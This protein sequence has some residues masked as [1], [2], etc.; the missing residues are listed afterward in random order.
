MLA[1]ATV[2][3]K[4]NRE[5]EATSG[6]SSGW[7]STGCYLNVHDELAIYLEADKAKNGMIK[8]VGTYIIKEGIPSSNFRLHIY[9]RDSAT[10]GPGEDITDSELVVH[11]RRGNEWVTAN[12][13][14]HYIQAHGGV[15]VS[16]EWL[17]DNT[18][19]FH[20]FNIPFG[21]ANYYSGVDS[22]RTVFNGQV[23]GMTWQDRQPKIYR[24]YATDLYAHKDE[25]KWQPT[26]PLRGGHRGKGWIVPM[27]YY[28]YSYV[29]R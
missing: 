6:I 22:F 1:G 7:H 17:V 28:T 16:V 8:E 19:A 12:L 11:A 3:A 27:I 14:D 10:G 9:A 26:P 21:T 29:E 24:R 23:V 4:G 13:A 18:D 25:G 5:R 20:P 2:G 15:F